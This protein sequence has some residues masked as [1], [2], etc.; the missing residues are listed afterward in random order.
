LAPAA[1][2]TAD[3]A[4]GAASDGAVGTVRSELLIARS[5][6]GMGV[7]LELAA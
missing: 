6:A 1:A 3:G 2:N 4:R 5:A 7:L